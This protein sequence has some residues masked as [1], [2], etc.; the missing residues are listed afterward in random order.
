M[1]EIEMLQATRAFVSLQ[2]GYRQLNI[3][4]LL[5]EARIR[6]TTRLQSADLLIIDTESMGNELAREVRAFVRCGDRIPVIYTGEQEEHFGVEQ[7]L[8]QWRGVSRGVRDELARQAF[9]LCAGR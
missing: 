7:S 4:Q 5:K 9:A 3:L 2:P 6:V 1:G 8:A